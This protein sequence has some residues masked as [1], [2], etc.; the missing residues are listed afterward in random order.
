[1]YEHAH[2]ELDSVSGF[3]LGGDFFEITRDNTLFDVRLSLSLVLFFLLRC[4]LT[5]Q[6]AGRDDSSMNLLQ[7]DMFI[8]RYRPIRSLVLENRVDLI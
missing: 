8:V 3:W 6:A 5:V 7:G 4:A 1:M 2:P